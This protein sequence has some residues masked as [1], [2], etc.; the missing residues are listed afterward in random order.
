M[1]EPDKLTDNAIK[2]SLSFWFSSGTKNDIPTA[3]RV[4]A[5]LGNVA[6]SKDRRPTND[7]RCQCLS[8]QRGESLLTGVNCEDGWNGENKVQ[9]PESY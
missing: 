3:N 9:S 6:R 4:Q 7:I 2:P 5:I 8:E 1:D